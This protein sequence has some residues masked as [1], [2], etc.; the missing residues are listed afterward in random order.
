MGL[1]SGRG[2]LSGQP[3][4]RWSAP[5]PDGLTYLEPFPRRVRAERGG[6]T[7]VD[8]ERVVLVHRPGAPPVWAFPRADV[9]G[10]SS[11]PEPLVPGYVRVPW[12]AADAWFEEQDQVF[13]HPRNPYHRVDCVPSGRRLEVM[14]AGV[15]VVDSTDTVGVY[16]TA[17]AP[18]LYVARDAVRPGA[19]MASP[20]TTYCPY[21]GTATYWS[22]TAGGRTVQD[23]AWSYEDPFPEC[24]AIRGM[25]CFDPARVEVVAALPWWSFSDI[26]VAVDIEEATPGPARRDPQS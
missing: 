9:T 2:P 4:G 20:T 1:T 8:S 6:T 18:R 12:E 7:V 5:V 17:M 26:D 13:G 22:V 21:K 15:V 16:E 3:A 23:A 24:G 14:L 11:E 25:V 19:L 10:V